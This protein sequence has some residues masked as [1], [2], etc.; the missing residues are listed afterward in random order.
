MSLS[1][2]FTARL[3]GGVG[4][5]VPGPAVPGPTIAGPI[6]PGPIVPG[7]IVRGV[8]GTADGDPNGVNLSEVFLLA[9]TRISHSQSY[10][11]SRS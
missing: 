10:G 8:A 6:M 3:S 1:I 11:V 4:T 2:I 5:L 9:L 7:P